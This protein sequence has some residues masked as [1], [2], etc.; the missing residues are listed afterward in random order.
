MTI[1]T[2]RKSLSELERETE[3]T[4]AD[5][6]CTVDELRSRMAPQALKEDLRSYA[7]E[8]SQSWLRGLQDRA[9]ENPLQTV[10]IAAGL[11]YPAWRILMNIPVPVL[12]VGAG[13]ALSRSNNGASAYAQSSVDAATG[14]LNRAKEATAATVADSVDTIKQ[15]AAAAAGQVNQA[16]DSAVQAGRAQVNALT[17]KATAAV[18]AA[19]DAAS[20]IATKVSDTMSDAY[21]TGVESVAQVG[22]QIGEFAT[23]TRETVVEAI[24]SHP[25]AIGAVGL[26][27]GGFIASVLPVTTVE[28]EAFGA[29]SDALK[30]RAAKM[31]TDAGEQLTTTA[32]EVYQ[33]GVCRLQENGVTP[34]AA[35]AAVRDA[36]DKIKQTVQQ[37]TEKNRDTIERS[38]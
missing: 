19:S 36:G 4:R 35:S 28:N 9:R 5:L 2:R 10:A 20:D 12:L 15:Q 7:N 18:S 29:T 25:L 27:I 11:A 26:A 8:T 37:V 13:L 38:A 33:N 32:H 22:D 16:M 14:A 34:D 17:E 3:R 21:R 31:A 23:Q 6:D 1:E 30:Q 24:E